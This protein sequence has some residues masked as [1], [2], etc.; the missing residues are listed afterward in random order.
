MK[1]TISSVLARVREN[2]DSDS[3]LS[4]KL[5]TLGDPALLLHKTFHE[6]G[7]EP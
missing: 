2:V 4:T 7:E 5:K 1:P 3:N 6:V